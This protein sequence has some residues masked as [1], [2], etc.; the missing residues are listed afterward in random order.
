MRTSRFWGLDAIV[1]AANP[2]LEKGSGVCDAIFKGA[3]LGTGFLERQC[4]SLAGCAVG[5][6]VVTDGFDLPAKHI[7]HAVGPD[8]K[9]AR[10]PSM[11]EEEQLNS[12]YVNS[13]EMAVNR[14]FETI[15]FPALST[16]RYL[17]PSRRSRPRRVQHGAR[18]P[19][20]GK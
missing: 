8:L 14:G 13:L 15:A 6:V 2:K 16:G 7:I 19:G 10:S 17:Y 3:G 9:S 5:N 18:L 11:K 1:N 4:A 20:S 12:C